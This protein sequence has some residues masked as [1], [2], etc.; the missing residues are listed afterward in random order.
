MNIPQRGCTRG[1]D[2]GG[3]GGEETRATPDAYRSYHNGATDWPGLGRRFSTHK[4]T[5]TPPPPPS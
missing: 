3:S 2:D 1:K 5:H 4:H